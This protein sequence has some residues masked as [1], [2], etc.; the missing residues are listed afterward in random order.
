MRVPTPAAHV[1][2]TTKLG[3]SIKTLRLLCTRAGRESLRFLLP[4]LGAD[5]GAGLPPPMAPT[6]ADYQHAR[7]FGGEVDRLLRSSFPAMT[8]PAAWFA[9]PLATVRA[10]LLLPEQEQRAGAS[11]SARTVPPSAHEQDRQKIAWLEQEMPHSAAHPPTGKPWE[12]DK[13]A[14]DRKRRRCSGRRTY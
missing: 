14:S 5:N 8:P 11:A 4:L 3:A 10:L 6:A 2:P 12:T 13:L 1:V 7:A 9:A